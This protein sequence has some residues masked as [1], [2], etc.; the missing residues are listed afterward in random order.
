MVVDMGRRSAK[1]A[2]RKVSMEHAGVS[3]GWCMG[4]VPFLEWLEACMPRHAEC[5][6]HLR[7]P[8]NE[9]PME[10]SWEHLSCW[11]CSD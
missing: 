10:T 1:I 7:V 11:K 8:S 2:L 6:A 5:G 9:V 4:P 3:S